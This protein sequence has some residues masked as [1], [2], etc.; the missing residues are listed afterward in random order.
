VS[1][2]NSELRILQH[3]QAQDT[4][5]PG[6]KYLPQL[7]GHFYEN[8]PASSAGE[9]NLFLVLEL[10]GPSLMDMKTCALATYS[11]YFYRRTTKQLLLAVD[12]LHSYGI[13]HGGRLTA[14][15]YCSGSNL[16]EIFT[17]VMFY[18]AFQMVM[19]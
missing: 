4:G 3:I 7:L 13:V 5:H 1:E 11:P 10:L 16:A 9:R 14:K 2:N 15:L 18:S 17:R 8:K 19:S 6:R 12:C